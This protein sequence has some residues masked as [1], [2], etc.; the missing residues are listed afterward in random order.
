M[1]FYYHYFNVTRYMIFLKLMKDIFSPLK[2]K[3]HLLKTNTLHRINK[4]AH[5][6]GRTP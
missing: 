4:L 5:I 3:T 1:N 6:D 2:G